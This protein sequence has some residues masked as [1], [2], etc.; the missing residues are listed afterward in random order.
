MPVVARPSILPIPSDTALDTLQFFP[1]TLDDGTVVLGVDDVAQFA[2]IP[3][4]CLD[5]ASLVGTHT[6]TAL[7]RG[8]LPFDLSTHAA[9]STPIAADML[10]RLAEDVAGYAAQQ[11][12]SPMVA[13][14]LSL[15][16]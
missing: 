13:L 2:G 11:T 4:T 6:R 1:L 7:P 9:A 12:A 3:L 8:T 15:Q 10:A 16:V 5:L 14:R